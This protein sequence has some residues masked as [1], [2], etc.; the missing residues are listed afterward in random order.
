MK[1]LTTFLMALMLTWIGANAQTSSWTAPELP[2]QA[3]TLV[4]GGKYY[5]YNTEAEQFMGQVHLQWG[6]EAGFSDSGLLVTLDSSG[7]DYTIQTSAGYV[8]FNGTYLYIDGASTAADP[9]TFT[10]ASDGTYTIQTASEGYLGYD[11][12]AEI[13]TTLASSDTGIYWELIAEDPD[14]DMDLHHALVILY[15]TLVHAESY[16]M[17]DD[18]DAYKEAGEVYLSSDATVDDVMAAV[19]A[20]EVAMEGLASEADPDEVTYAYITNPNFDDGDLSGWTNTGNMTSQGTNIFVNENEG[21]TISGYPEKWVASANSLEDAKISQTLANLPVGTYSLE[22]DAIAVKQTTESPEVTGVYLYASSLTTSMTSV[23]TTDGLP[24]HY[25]VSFEVAAEGTSVEIGFEVSSTNAN[26]VAVDNFRLYYLSSEVTEVTDTPSDY[27]NGDVATIYGHKYNVKSDN[28]VE[29]HSFELGFTGW[30][31]AND[32][33][34]EI[35]SEN[36]EIRTGDAQDGNNYLVGTTNGGTASAGSLGKAWAIEAGKTYYFSYYIKA[37]LPSTSTNGSYMKVSLA[38]TEELGNGHEDYMI[39]DGT[40]PVS[41][42][43]QKVEAMFTN[44]DYK[45]LQIDFRWLDSQ[46]AFDNFQIYEVEPAEDVLDDSEYETGDEVTV[47]GKAYTVVSDNLFV[48]GGFNADMYGWTEAGYILAADPANFDVETTGGFNNGAYL[49]DA[50]AGTGSVKTPSQA[51]AV[52]EGKTYLFIGYTSGTTP[53]EGNLRYSALFEMED[54]TT[55]ASHTEEDNKS[56]AN[57]IIQLEWG[58]DPEETATDWTQTIGVFTVPAEGEEDTFPYVGMRM[59]WSG[60][61]YDGFQL[62][63]VEA[64]PETIEWEMTAAEWGTIILPFEADVPDG[65]TAY[66]C[67]E[68]TGDELV[69]TEA[70]TLEANTPYIMAG[71][72]GEYEFTGVAVDAENGLTAGLLTGTYETMDC[73]A[74]LEAAGTGTVYLLQNQTDVDGVAFY[75]VIEDESAEATLT[76]NHC[77][78]LVPSSVSPTALRLPG[79]ATAIEAVEGDVIAND[80]IYDLSGRRVSKAVK[81]VYIQNGKKVLV[82]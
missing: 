17:T 21:I 33:T 26:W 25:A 57:T 47:D 10:E 81:G 75:P 38:A 46:W 62:Y 7:S 69:L 5:L 63:E 20:L 35:T 56:Y 82:K 55:E 16:G 50:S 9:F 31:G 2:L 3:S 19:A 80:A 68:V 74:L 64:V 29:N 54:A 43:W 18:I 58:A 6:T 28:M 4:D 44:A 79:M 52:E 71:A 49:I 27:S 15:N 40:N 48:N 1:R 13:M 76:A 41:E 51:I 34:T 14:F 70:T 12:T 60:G 42:D 61:S 73:D 67:D 24:A 37:L 11:G 65:L 66:S 36:F 72:E 22:A 59:G 45:Y 30:T 77:Y 23:S 32:F 53:G 39:I 78:L 8:F